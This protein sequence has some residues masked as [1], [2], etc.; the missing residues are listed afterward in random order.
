MESDR[1]RNTPGTD[2]Q[3]E[4]AGTASSGSDTGASRPAAEKAMKQEQKTPGESG[5]GRR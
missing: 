2:M 3:A 1:T 5:S 4:D